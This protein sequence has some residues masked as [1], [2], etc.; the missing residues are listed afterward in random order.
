MTTKEKPVDWTKPVQFSNGEECTVLTTTCP[1]T[2]PVVVMDK[3]GS[4]YKHSID[5]ESH[6]CGYAYNIIN[7]SEE[8]VRY[9]NIYETQS[10]GCTYLSLS[11]ANEESDSCRT[12]ILKLTFVDGVPV[13][14]EIIPV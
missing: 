4:L 5:G 1:G 7:K 9:L 10:L 6:L 11:E 3:D 12:G 2:Y 13:K 14:S 8:V